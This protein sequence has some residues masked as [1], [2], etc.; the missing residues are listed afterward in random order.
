MT[1]CREPTIVVQHCISATKEYVRAQIILRGAGSILKTWRGTDQEALNA[2]RA[3][4][5][6]MIKMDECDN[7]DPNRGCLGHP[8]ETTKAV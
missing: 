2:V 4:P 3:Q 6:T 5:G 1:T 8:P 7:F